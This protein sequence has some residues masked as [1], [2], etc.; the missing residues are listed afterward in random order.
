MRA[1]TRQQGKFNVFYNLYLT[2]I[3]LVSTITTWVFSLDLNYGQN[4]FIT[5]KI[6]STSGVGSHI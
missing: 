5:I 3:L 2:F 6:V 4:S 1:K